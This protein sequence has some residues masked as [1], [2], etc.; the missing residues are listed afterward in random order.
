MSCV[1]SQPG[2][3]GAI[4]NVSL[5][6]N[7]L[8]DLWNL[9]PSCIFLNHGSYGAVPRN[10][11][12][13]Q[14]RLHMHIEE[15]PVR[16]FRDEYAEML[17]RARRRLAAF[18]GADPEEIVFV[19][20]ATTGVNTVLKSFPFSPG[21]EILMTDHIYN[22]C[23]NAV[24]FV[25]RRQGIKLK[26]LHVPFPLD[27]QETVENLV[28]ANVTPETRMVLLDHVT[29]PTAL[30]F[31]CETLSRKLSAMGIHVL[32]DGAHAPGMIPLNLKA[33]NVAFYT[34]NCHKWLCAPKGSAFLYIRRDLSDQVRPLVI[35]HGANSTRTDKS[36]LHLEF[37]WVGTSD[38]TP[39][40]MIPECLDFLD[41]LYP[42]GILDLMTRNHRLIVEAA[43]MLCEEFEIDFPCPENMV[44]SMISL[45]I[46][47]L[48][49]PEERPVFQKKGA[50][51][52]WIQEAL[53]STF[54]IEVPIIPW[55]PADR[56][57]V[58]ISCQAY[59]DMADYRAMASA[60]KRIMAD[61]F[62]R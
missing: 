50:Q 43:R 42:G 37:D 29:S 59:N 14:Y 48:K 38:Y 15:N 18:L 60:L 57:L 52:D 24:E 62:Q 21:D 45:P 40:L 26:M 46:L 12:E 49:D 10:I 4:S 5:E 33:M 13:A 11:I 8:K 31:P 6:T 22:A 47:P 23:R 20:N 55:P 39:Y 35:S 1:F 9:D 7:N 54:N 51:T 32:V 61:Y 30:V 56:R 53:Y 41:S 19:P 25:A 27:S 3:R 36:F 34:G 17:S 2:K 58:R 28:L 44:G 16:F